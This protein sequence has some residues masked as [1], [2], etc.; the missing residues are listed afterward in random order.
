MGFNSLLTCGIVQTTQF[1]PLLIT[2][3]H[4]ILLI[5]KCLPPTS[6]TIHSV[7]KG[8]TPE[9]CALCIVLLPQIMHTCD[10]QTSVSVTRTELGVCVAQPIALGQ[11]S[12]PH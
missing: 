3:E 6:L 1:D 9:H 11:E 8:N 5:L 4:L 2:G 12:L 10:P 7:P